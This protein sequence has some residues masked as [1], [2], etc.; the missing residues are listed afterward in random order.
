MNGDTHTRITSLPADKRA[1]LLRKF[2]TRAARA[3]LKPADCDVA[4]IGGGVAGMTLALQ[5]VQ[6]APDVRVVVLE[7]EQHPVPETAHKVGESTV[8]IAAHYLRD[9]IGLD[10]HLRAQQLQKFGLRMFFSAGGNDDI[11]RRVE[12]GSSV[13]PPLTTYQLDRGR[14]ENALASRCL[15]HGVD[16]R[17]LCK[18]ERVDLASGDGLHVVHVRE[19][20]TSHEIRARWVVDASG[21]RR[22][23]Q[24]QLGLAKPD[25]HAANAAWFRIAHPIDIKEWTADP[26]WHGRVTEGDRALST[27]HLMGPGYWVWLIRLSSDAISI[28]I[29]ADASMHP[30]EEFNQFERALQ[31]LRQH[32]PQCAAAVQQ[33]AGQV[34]DFKVMKDYSY[35]C[36]QVFSGAGRWC[37]TG[38]AGLF[39]DPLYSPGLDMIAIS[40]GLVTDLVSRDLAGQDVTTRAAIHDKLFLRLADIW[41]AIYRGQ[42]TLM[43]NAEVATSKVIWDTA[44]YW[45]VFGLLFFNDKFRSMIEHPAVADGLEKLTLIS[46]RMQAFLR[47]WDA[48]GHPELPGGFVDLY[49]PLNFMVS[50]HEGIAVPVAPDQF[51]ARFSANVRLFEQLAG[52]LVSTVMN[53]YANRPRSGVALE[54]IQ[55]WQTDP[56]LR[57]LIAI[58]RR[59]AKVNPTSDRWITL[60]GEALI[61]QP[62]L[63]AHD[64]LVTQK[65]LVAVATPTGGK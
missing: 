65:E 9:I 32:E 51:E 58:Y 40:N 23:L 56:L 14:L 12:L 16:Y 30:F 6:S 35:G 53:A 57:E 7:R 62:G 63:V 59:E 45:G 33:H 11:A 29:V 54:Q 64:D 39:L 25:G 49:K 3:R 46:N 47:E 22:L 26:G 19:G 10:E 36:T 43:G 44:F 20:D 24:R 2:A 31:W 28:G 18:V 42:Y 41:L 50:L 15:E 4:I 8:E 17:Q 13:F 27:N 37:V 48:L 34:Q 61:T 21:R 38:E 5:L 1:L 52:Q 55:R 60:S